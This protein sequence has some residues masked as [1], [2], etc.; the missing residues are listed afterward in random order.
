VRAAAGAALL[1]LAACIPLSTP[2]PTPGTP[3]ET[4]AL[5]SRALQRTVLEGAVLGTAAGAAGNRVWGYATP[6]GIVGG[7]TVGTVT[8]TYLGYLQNRYATN[9]ERLERIRYDME[10]T[11]QE[12]A[13][14]VA[15]M[16]TVLAQQRAQLA[17]ARAA[18]PTP[19]ASDV[20]REVAEAQENLA[21]MQLATRGA[22]NRRQEFLATAPL[23]LVGGQTT[24][25]DSQV[26]EL[27]S[28]IA[29][30]RAIADTLAEEI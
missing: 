11:N 29:S 15:T 27:E 14:T 3:E 18:A 25:V 24:G 1:A 23:Q 5:Q 19:A 13:E 4:L 12:T 9:E 16:Q 28:R 6:I 17:A 8:G 26:A 21:N 30:M 20:A 2:E 10:L 22:E 7:G